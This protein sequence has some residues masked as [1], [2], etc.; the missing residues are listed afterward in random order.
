MITHGFALKQRGFM[1]CHK[2]F[3]CQV[4]LQSGYLPTMQGH[5]GDMNLTEMVRLQ[6]VP[7]QFL[8]KDPC[9]PR[10]AEI[11]TYTMGVLF[12]YQYGDGS[13]V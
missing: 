4:S 9:K 7:Q 13:N 12:F 3:Q 8:I 1:G 5:S 2:I 6:S 11:Y 10:F